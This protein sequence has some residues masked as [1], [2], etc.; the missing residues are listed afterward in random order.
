MVRVMLVDDHEI[1]RMGLKMLLETL[2]NYEVVCEA[3]NG[4]EALNC[5]AK[6]SIDLIL[7]DLKM[8]VMDGLSFLDAY[9]S[10]D[11]RVPVVI[12][13]TL[14]D[15]EKIKKG[16]A[17]G[18]KSYMLKDASRDTLLRTLEAALKDEMLLT[19]DVSKKLLASEAPPEMTENVEDFGLTERELFI[20]GCVAKGETNK[21]ISIDLGIS[22]RTVKAHLTNLYAKM[23]VTSRSEAVAKALANRLIHVQG[24]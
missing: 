5:L 2:D 22:E 14:D 20:L 19:S 9:Q 11:H 1:V 15:Q 17:L 12:L 13:T 23:S 10:S 8:P 3:E 7:L 6:Q 24:G 16:I 4:Q 21:S 18:A